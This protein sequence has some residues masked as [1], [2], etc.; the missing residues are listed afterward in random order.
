MCLQ[1]HISPNTIKFFVFKYW[2]NRYVKSVHRQYFFMLYQIFLFIKCWN[3]Y[4]TVTSSRKTWNIDQKEYI[5]VWIFYCT[6]FDFTSDYFLIVFLSHLQYT[7]KSVGRI[8]VSQIYDNFYSI[9]IYFVTRV[10]NPWPHSMLY[11][12][13]MINGRIAASMNIIL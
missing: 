9:W 5:R 10:A 8:L 13:F 1:W 7:L 3:F 4:G 2:T 6:I 12:N 11:A